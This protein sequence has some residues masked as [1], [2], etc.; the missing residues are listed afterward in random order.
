MN[1]NKPLPTPDEILTLLFGGPPLTPR[2]LLTPKELEEK[3]SKA[4]IEFTRLLKKRGFEGMD[5]ADALDMAAHCSTSLFLK[6]CMVAGFDYGAFLVQHRTMTADELNVFENVPAVKR[7][8]KLNDDVLVLV[9]QY[10]KDSV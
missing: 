9:D 10:L 3:E 5:G 1:D 6:E 4:H 7:F 2:K 8:N